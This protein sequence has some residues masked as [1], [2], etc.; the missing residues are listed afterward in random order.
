MTRYLRTEIEGRKAELRKLEDLNREYLTKINDINLQLRDHRQ[1]MSS[2]SMEVTGLTLNIKELEEFEYPRSDEI[3]QIVCILILNYL[4]DDKAY[5]L[6][7]FLI[8]NKKLKPKRRR[9]IS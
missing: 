5:E 8:R 9:S 4:F 2:V 3:L 7:S 1:Q 6:C